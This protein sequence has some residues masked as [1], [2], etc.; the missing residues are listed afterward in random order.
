M[1]NPEMLGPASLAIGNTVNSFGVFLPKLTD[2]RR[3]TPG[4]QSIIKDV[5]LGQIGA[6]AVAM[7]FGAIMSSLSGSPI[8]VYVSF[9]MSAVIIGLYEQALRSTP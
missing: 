8:P 9:F 4:D 3:A 1:P 5:R 2:V 7:G 6:V